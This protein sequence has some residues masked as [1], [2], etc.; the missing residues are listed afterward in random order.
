MFLLATLVP[1]F[2]LMA[3]GYLVVKRGFISGGSA[4]DLNNLVYYIGLPALLFFRIGQS[5]VNVSIAAKPVVLCAIS[6]LAG[7]LLGI[8]YVVLAKKEKKDAGSIVQATTRA[9]TVFLGL[10]I[11]FYFFENIGYSDMDHIRNLAMLSLAIL[12]PFNNI[13]GVVV[14]VFGRKT[15][16]AFGKVVLKNLSTNPI[17]LACVAGAVYSYFFEQFPLPI[18]RTLQAMSGMTLPLSLIAVGCVLAEMKLSDCCK[19][20]AI[21]SI[22]KLLLMPLLVLP[23]GKMLGF[24]GPDIA[25]AMIL[26][27]CPTASTSVTLAQQLGG[28]VKLT[29]NVVFGTSVLSVFSLIVVLVLCRGLFP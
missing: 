24:A 7:I 6:M 13:V 14:L 23:V 29:S 22:I 10:P 21:I 25:V 9:N 4:R 3:V 2:A 1:V 11:I 27:A 28:N 15:E 5:D 18:S 26:M 20:I 16:Q 12:V 19:D 8:S 17:I